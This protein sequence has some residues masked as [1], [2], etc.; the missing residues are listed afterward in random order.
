MTV[1]DRNGSVES[2]VDTVFDY[3]CCVFREEEMKK[4]FALLNFTFFS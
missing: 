4:N 1:L 2:I 3:P